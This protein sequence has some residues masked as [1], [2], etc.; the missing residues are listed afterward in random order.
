MKNGKPSVTAAWVAA[1]RRFGAVLPPEARLADDP[2]G[3]RFFG[4]AIERLAA[5]AA[6]H[7]EGAVRFF[8]RTDRLGFIQAMQVRTRALDDALLAFV[9]DGGRQIILLGAGFDCRAARFRDALRGATVFEIDHPATQARKREVVG[10]DG[11]ER[12]E[13]VAW[14]FENDP[15]AALGDRLASRGHDRGARTLT[16]WEGV[17]MY[18]TERAIDDCVAAVGAL[19]A[20]GSVFALTYFERRSIEV[21]QQGAKLVAMAGEPWRFGWEPRELPGWLDARGFE[22]LADDT[23]GELAARML[24]PSWAKEIKQPDAHVAVARRR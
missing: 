3:A 8:R 18:L 20:P 21:G 7:P 24:P 10:D 23:I 17:T 15:M 14:D 12:V 6:R 2:Y 13:Y 1:T 9:R 4:P 22:L 16:I 11:G 19:S 5:F